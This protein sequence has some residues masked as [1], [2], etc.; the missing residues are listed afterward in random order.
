MP[1]TV[2]ASVRQTVRDLPDLEAKVDAAVA[3]RV[4]GMD[5][6]LTAMSDRVR[7]LESEVELLRMRGVG[8]PATPTFVP[9]QPNPSAQTGTIQPG[10]GTD[11]S[12]FVPQATPLN[13]ES[14]PGILAR[15]RQ[16]D[17][18]VDLHAIRVVDKRLVADVSITRVM[19]G[20]GAFE[21][22]PSGRDARVI[23]ASGVELSRFNIAAPGE[24]PRHQ[25]KATLISQSPMRYE[26]SFEGAIPAIPFVCRRIEF[27]FYGEKG[28]REPLLFRF[29]NI[30]VTQ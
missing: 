3:K 21:V 9:A 23:T 26:I 22:P 14:V 12:S 11:S 1:E 4:A 5:Q 2:S 30:A 15:S 6:L 25:M 16:A 27:T 13:P 20:D 24:R 28:N 17:L 8:S 29:E 18:Q 10:T 7:I 19:A